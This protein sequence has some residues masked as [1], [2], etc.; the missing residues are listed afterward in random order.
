MERSTERATFTCPS[1]GT[2]LSRSETYRRLRVCDGCQ[3]HFRMTAHQRLDLLVDEGTFRETNRWLVSVDPLSF[4]DKVP[5]QKR[6]E[7]AQNRT[8]L[9]DAVVTGICSIGGK[10]VAL[11]VMDFEFMGG[12]MGSVVGEKIALTLPAAR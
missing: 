4:S 7:E 10:S 5:Y 12:T 6:L 8:G 11:A 2:D 1:C 3:H 9:I